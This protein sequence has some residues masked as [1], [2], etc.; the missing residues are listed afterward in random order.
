MK[1]AFA[2]LI[3]GKCTQQSGWSVLEVGERWGFRTRNRAGN[4]MDR[5]S[6]LE[7]GHVYKKGTASWKMPSDAFPASKAKP[8]Q[9]LPIS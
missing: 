2:L 5:S 6:D 4:K 7:T 8:S 3:L 1:N 9:G